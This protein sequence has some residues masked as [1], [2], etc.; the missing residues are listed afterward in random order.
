ML[1]NFYNAHIDNHYYIGRHYRMAN[2][3]SSHPNKIYMKTKIHVRDI[4]YII[5][6]TKF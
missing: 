3:E 5:T 6:Y 1:F 4:K 2:R